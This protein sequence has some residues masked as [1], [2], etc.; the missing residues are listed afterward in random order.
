MTT[1]DTPAIPLDRLLDQ[2]LESVEVLKYGG[3]DHPLVD[4]GE[5]EAL[6][7]S[8]EELRA[9]LRQER[10]VTFGMGRRLRRL[11]ARR[12]ELDEEEAAVLAQYAEGRGR[13]DSQIGELE[14]YLESLALERRGRGEKSFTIPGVGVWK[15][16]VVAAGFGV[17]K[18]AALDHLEGDDRALYVKTV[19]S[20]ELD[21]DA[22][23]AH[24]AKLIEETTERIRA[25]RWASF[26]ETTEGSTS[27]AEAMLEIAVEKELEGVLP[28]GVIRR[29]ARVTVSYDLAAREE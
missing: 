19:E 14:G 10:A 12:R 15:T 27:D 4:L 23:R 2:L 26:L 16:R 3:P 11:L 25:E 5:R 7:L 24:V 8:I 9:R 22:F 29:P 28:R 20:E 13:L 21:G 6:E 18:A 1:A 17:D